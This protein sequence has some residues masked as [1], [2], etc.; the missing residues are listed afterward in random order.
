MWRCDKCSTY[1]THLVSHLFNGSVM[2]S[3]SPKCAINGQLVAA[4][5]C[6]VVMKHKC[7]P[8]TNTCRYL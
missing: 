1:N 8:Q 4:Y 3:L 7:G 5:A 6:G 2:H